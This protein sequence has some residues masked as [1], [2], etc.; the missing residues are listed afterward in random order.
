MLTLIRQTNP[1]MVQP[2]VSGPPMIKKI[3]INIIE[4]ET[5]TKHSLFK[6]LTSDDSSVTCKT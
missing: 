1:E 3:I 4:T 5:T 2:N 6:H